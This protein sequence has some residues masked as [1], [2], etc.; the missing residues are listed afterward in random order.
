MRIAG[1][2]Q[3]SIV[4]GPGLRF[5]VFTQGCDIGCAGCHNPESTD[6]NGG[7]EMAV[8]DIMA[9]MLS[10][11]LTDG[12]TLSGGEPFLQAADCAK[13]AAAARD[14]GKNVWT[15]TGN[16]FENMLKRAQIEPAVSDLLELTDVLVDGQFIL[17]QR[18]LSMK[19]RG[20]KN[21]RFIDVQK[22][23]IANKVIEFDV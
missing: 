17:A 22:S 10:N 6:I 2:I 20:S 19:W 9:V 7:V 14:G 11:P 15:Y 1:L 4:D 5:V 13:L 16:N 3:D 12:L 23:L 8:E 18:T 21:Q